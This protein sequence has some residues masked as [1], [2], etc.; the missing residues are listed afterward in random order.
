M[1]L[2]DASYPPHV[3]LLVSNVVEVESLLKI[4]RKL[5]GPGPGRRHVEV[6]NK[7]GIVVLVACWEA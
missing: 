6:L 7:S 2:L 1:K 4:H 5:T 3:R